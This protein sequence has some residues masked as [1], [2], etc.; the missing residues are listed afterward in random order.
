MASKPRR[1]LTLTPFGVARYVHLNKPDVYTNPETGVKGS[2]KYKVQ[3]LLDGADRDAFKGQIDELIDDAWEEH[4]AN[5]P[6][7]KKKKLRKQ[8]PYDAELDAD[9]EE[10]GRIAFKFTSNAEFK[11]AKGEVEDRR[12]PLILDAKRIPTP[13]APVWSGSELRVAFSTRGYLN[14][15]AQAVSVSLDLEKVQIKSLAARSNRPDNTFDEVEG[16]S[17]EAEPTAGDDTPPEF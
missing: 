5:I 13:N 9:G 15:A 14:A 2:P 6:D 7:S 16:W 11:N 4:T 10:T 1:T 17:N 12:P 3:L 8:Y